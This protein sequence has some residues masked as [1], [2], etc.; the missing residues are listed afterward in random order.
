MTVNDLK[1]LFAKNGLIVDV[2]QNGAISIGAYD[3]TY[4]A[5][6]A[7]AGANSNIVST[8]FSE[9]DFVNIYTS[10][11]LTVPKDVIQAVNKDTKLSD[12]NQGTYQAGFITVVKDGVQT[13]IELTADDTIGTFMNQLALYGFETVIN[14][15]GQLIIKNTGNSLLQNTPAPVKLRIFWN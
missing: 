1:A 8:L 13:N 5:T 10:N 14:D 12:I 11:G 9:W 2:D 4:L 15:K 7:T 3:N 6:S